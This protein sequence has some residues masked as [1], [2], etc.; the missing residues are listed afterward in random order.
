MKFDIGVL[1]ENSSKRE[2]RENRLSDIRTLGFM[3]AGMS[4]RVVGL[5]LTD[6]WKG[7]SGLHHQMSVFMDCLNFDTWRHNDHSKLRS[8]LIQRQGVTSEKTWFRRN[9]VVRTSHLSVTLHL[10]VSMNSVSR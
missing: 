8:Q 3:S 10:L 5:V 2:F 7:T 4:P 1:D 9:T 6:V